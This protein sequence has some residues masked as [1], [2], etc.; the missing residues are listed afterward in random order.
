MDNDELLKKISTIEKHITGL[1]SKLENCTKVN[2]IL[3]FMMI[4]VI[5]CIGLILIVFSIIDERNVTVYIPV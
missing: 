5:I 4:S 2:N 1:E 3:Q